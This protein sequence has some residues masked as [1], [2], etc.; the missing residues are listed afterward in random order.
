MLRVVGIGEMIIS[1]DTEDII[2]TFALA[3]C[4]GVVAYSPTKKVGGI[5]HIAL[6]DTC[7]TNQ[8]NFRLCYYA[9]TGLPYFIDELHRRYKCSREE[10]IIS[11]YGG[12]DSIR[13]NDVFDVG[14]KNI[15]I[16]YHIINEMHL[17][18]DRV[19]IGKNVSRTIELD[20]LNGEIN[21]WRQKLII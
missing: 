20:V 15:E 1:N 17:K 2:K 12:A 5:L 8:G 9:S 6:P 11:I 3:S 7:A 19:E 4:V 21:I 18:V 14:R 10:L 13:L 16:V